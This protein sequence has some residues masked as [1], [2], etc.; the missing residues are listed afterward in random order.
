METGEHSIVVSNGGNKE[1]LK[2]GV[3]FLLYKLGDL[4]YAVNNKERLISDGRL[5]KKLYINEIA[6]AKEMDL[7]NFKSNIIS[8][9]DN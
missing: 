7:Y 4:D 6:K 5:K 1:Y 8:L 3:N 9:F 2:D